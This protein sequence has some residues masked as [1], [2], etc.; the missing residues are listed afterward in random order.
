MTSLGERTVE[1]QAEIAQAQVELAEA[2]RAAEAELQQIAADVVLHV[3]SET[4]A[5]KRRAALQ[6][7]VA[8]RRE[9]LRLLEASLPEI[10]R[11]RLAE[12][13]RARQTALL[14][15][16]KQVASAAAARD[17]AAKHVA[18]A[19]TA[20]ADAAREL[21]RHR[22]FVAQ[23][24]AAEAVLLLRHEEPTVVRDE[25]WQIADDVLDFVN[26]GPERPDRESPVN[27][28]FWSPQRCTGRAA[29]RASTSASTASATTRSSAPERRVVRAS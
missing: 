16:R 20:L 11:R 7:D 21:Q 10:E 3:V 8:T 18:R 23:A 6:A 28:P 12:E 13:E 25:D 9:R 22:P 27:R 24:V 15:A 29:G 14:K 5:L 19:I 2:E 1:I 26:A 17:S 4:E